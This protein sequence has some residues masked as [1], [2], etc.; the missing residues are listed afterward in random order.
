MLKRKRGRTGCPTLYDDE[1]SPT[2][3]MVTE[4]EPVETPVPAAGT[5]RRAYLW[6]GMRVSFLI[7]LA[8]VIFVAIAGVLSLGYSITAPTWVK[9]RVEAN[10]AALL[11][12][13]T[14]SFGEIDVTV[15]RDLH[16][17][18]VL[19]NTALKDAHGA[20]LA[21]VPRI[22]ARVSPR[23][24]LFRRE[25]L[26]QEVR[27]QGAQLSLRRAADGSVA[28]AFDTSAE[29]VGQAATFAELLDQTDQF[30]ERPAL[31]ALEEVWAEGVIINYTDNRAARN[32][33][34]DG[35]TLGLDL[36]GG[37][38]RLTGDVSLLSGRDYITTATLKYESPR[39]SRLADINLSIRDIVASDIA[40]Q[41][42]ALSWL[43]V[44][45]ARMT[46]DL[47][48]S[49]DAKGNLGPLFADL[50]IEKGEV[51]A[52]SQA[53]PLVFDGASVALSYDPNKAEID[54]AQLDIQ[55]P[56]GGFSGRGHA[57]L[58]Q[59]A[60]GWP[61]SIT[62]QMDFDGVTVGPESL[63]EVP[64]DLGTVSVQSRLTL[65]PF[66]LELGEVQVGQGDNAIRARAIAEAVPNGWDLGID[67]AAEALD[68]DR[69]LEIWPV[70]YLPLTRV[71]VLDNLAQSDLRGLNASL[72]FHPET[73]P[74][75]AANWQFSN[76]EV[77]FMKGLPPLEDGAG[78][79]TLQDN[80]LT[81]AIEKGRI[82]APQGGLV[83]VAGSSFSILNTRVYN[84][85]GEVR[86]K[87]NSTIT[88]ALAILDTAPF[89]YMTAAGL[90]MTLADGRALA[91]GTIEFPLKPILGP[92]DTKFDFT[93]KLTELRSSVLVPDHVVTA[94]ELDLVANLEDGL[95]ISG[96]ARLGQI[97]GRGLW[98]RPLGPGV[99]RK[100][101]LTAEVNLDQAFLDELN[102]GLPDGTLRGSG[103][104][105][106]R[107]DLPDGTAPTFE[108]SSN[109]QGLRLGL[110]AVGW[111]KAA[112][113][114]GKLTVSGQLGQQPRIDLLELDVA[115]LAA[116]G[117]LSIAADGGLGQAQFER[118]RIGGWFDAPVT[119]RGRG[120][121]R[122]VRI[123]VAGG[124]MDFRRATF[125][126]SA[127]QGG[128][129]EIALDSIQISEGIALTDFRG[130]FNAEGGFSG[131]FTARLN[132]GAAVTGTV[133]P[134]SGRSAIRLRGTDAGL[135]FKSIGLIQKASGG[136]LDLVMIPTA[137]EGNYDCKL[138]V[139]DL[140]VKDAPALAGLLD[141]ISVVGLLQQM[142]GQG[143]AFTNVD[144]RFRLTQDQII[145]TEAS[146]VGPGLGISLYGTYTLVNTVMDFQGVV[147]P[148]YL[149]NGIGSILTRRGEG[150]I[151][152]NYT[153]RGP[154]SEMK[155]GVDPLSFL[156]P[157]MFRD[158]FRRPPPQV[159]Q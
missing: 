71:W 28:V 135:A 99:D 16:P 87:T 54:F 91:E 25:L 38:T 76:T 84:A 55:S 57:M 144:A 146:A 141:A 142:D 140:R 100:S 109:L 60:T 43:S 72:R 143:L 35:G 116:R 27:V 2:Y 95:Q 133:V 20:T 106:L 93:A 9:S 92:G 30:F 150:L 12:G 94:S 103:S 62:S 157:G 23:G 21:R 114:T 149:I 121:N 118:V 115:G 44:V 41:S 65:S 51:R 6:H 42:P 136:N 50:N 68:R 74:Q 67:I 32:W 105:A 18:V 159:G 56:I 19:T 127:G 130:S 5:K 125:G 102:I 138:E 40:T 81:F 158:I 117:R 156:T 112:D 4:P 134:Q 47:S 79:A 61:R 137:T 86:L 128:P 129:M 108:L 148:I 139:T 98:S 7:F 153:L 37:V 11:A 85:P 59:D 152:F 15:G 154:L 49:L 46:A 88:A 126:D 17:V 3:S 77:T 52:N 120:P 123:E 22:E 48:M 80:T 45:E 36:R 83:D 14:L 147:S 70:S 110:P 31:E 73:L 122:A 96:L 151:G 104:G 124:R 29:A 1:S 89:G 34:I 69:V 63:Y 13:G 39:Q 107:I 113:Q 131:Q 64:L 53:Q 119:L 101:V 26:V 90:P 58:D 66:K 78:F 82:A 75:I 24:L 132:G 33:T 145:V 8:P 111:S 10:A 97:S 155:V